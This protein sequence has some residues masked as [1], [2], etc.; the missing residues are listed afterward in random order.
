[1]HLRQSLSFLHHLTQWLMQLVGCLVTN[2]GNK[3]VTQCI[4][5]LK[6]CLMVDIIS[7]YRG[8]AMAGFAS[9]FN[10]SGGSGALSSCL[11]CFAFKLFWPYRSLLD[12]W[13]TIWYS[14]WMHAKPTHDA[15]AFDW[16]FGSGVLSLAMYE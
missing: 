11:Q 3:A 13:H 14:W 5:C 8:V 6:I 2:K 15:T 1:V 12:A 9:S 7:T 4:N 16:Q 10:R